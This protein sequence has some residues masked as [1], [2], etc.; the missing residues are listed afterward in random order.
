MQQQPF[1]FSLILAT[2]GRVDDLARFLRSLHAQSYRR[3]E[4][5]VVDQNEDD[6]LVPLL[7]IHKDDFPIVHLR[8]ARG[9][10]KARNVGLRHVSGDLVAFPDD[11]CW[12]PDAGLLEKVADFFAAHPERAG[13]TGRSEDGNGASDCR[14]LAHSATVTTSNVWV[15]ATSFTIFLRREAVEAVGD[16]DESLGV[17]AGTV[18]GAGEEID[19]VVRAVAAGASILYDPDLVVYHPCKELVRTDAFLHRV[20][21]YSC[22]AGRVIRKNRL[23]LNILLHMNLRSVGGFLVSITKLDGWKARL[24]LA[25][26]KGRFQGWL[27]SSETPLPVPVSKEG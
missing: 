26:I 23:S 8:S 17:G 25:K 11:D 20:E 16:F 3:F 19:Y 18:W 6:R 21:L 13:L 12:Y 22:G 9:L 14:W 10:S 15:A 5:I 24:Y 27:H 1:L 2:V 4:L 7:A